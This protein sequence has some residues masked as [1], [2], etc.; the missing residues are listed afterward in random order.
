MKDSELNEYLNEY[1]DSRSQFKLIGF[2]KDKLIEELESLEVESDSRKHDLNMII[3]E[4]EE[5]IDWVESE[6][7]S[8]FDPEQL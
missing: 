8:E 4:I 2:L 3:R 5:E 7:L 1:K 6:K